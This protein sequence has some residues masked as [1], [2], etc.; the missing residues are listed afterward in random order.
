MTP[1]YVQCKYSGKAGFWRIKVLAHYTTSLG[2]PTYA[3]DIL[4]ESSTS[5]A[6]L[7]AFKALHWMAPDN[8]ASLNPVQPF[9]VNPVSGR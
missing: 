2:L 5:F 3:K 9:S 8:I 4:K 1:I 7:T 6:Y